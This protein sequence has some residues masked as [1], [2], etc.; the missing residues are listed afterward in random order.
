MYLYFRAFHLLLLLLPPTQRDIGDFPRRE[1]E[2]KRTGT[3][4]MMH[5]M[6]PLRKS[7]GGRRMDSREISCVCGEKMECPNGGR[8]GNTRDRWT[9]KCSM[10]CNVM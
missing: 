6:C 5:F 1:R 4:E 10:Q 3:K 2:G 9:D 7:L 8:R